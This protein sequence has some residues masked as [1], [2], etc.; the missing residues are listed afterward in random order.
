MSKTQ[1]YLRDLKGLGI[2]D[3]TSFIKIV[4]DIGH[5]IIIYDKKYIVN[6]IEHDLGDDEQSIDIYAEEIKNHE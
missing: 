3:L 1:I 4:P 5:K 6:R 2:K